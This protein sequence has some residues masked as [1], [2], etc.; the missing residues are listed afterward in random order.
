MAVWHVAN[1][2]ATQQTSVRID[3]VNIAADK[4]REASVGAQLNSQIE[5]GVGAARNAQG[6]FKS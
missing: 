1:K 4:G 3:T 2:T 6:P 5:R